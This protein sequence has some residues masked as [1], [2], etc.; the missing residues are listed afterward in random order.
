MSDQGSTGGDVYLIPSTGGE[1]KDVTPGR[2][3][4]VAFIGWV[5]PKVIG[6]A[7]HVGGS[8]HITALDLS[9]GK[10][11][12]QANATFPETIGAGGLSMSVSLSHEHTLDVDPQL[13]R[14][15]SRGVGWAA[16]RR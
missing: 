7:E 12:P 16:Q 11:V 1:P 8:S 10:D 2:A 15:G 6:I 3:A 4:S 13:V 9:T 5:S 14:E